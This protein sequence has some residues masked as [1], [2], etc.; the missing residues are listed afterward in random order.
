MSQQSR[1][2]YRRRV[3]A[4]LS[5]AL[6]E[7]LCRDV[8]ADWLAPR[9]SALASEAARVALPVSALSSLTGELLHAEAVVVQ[10]TFAG[11]HFELSPSPIQARLNER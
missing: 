6:R 2:V 4:S 1:D 9:L 7:G 10:S 11:L 8:Q 3:Q 5:A